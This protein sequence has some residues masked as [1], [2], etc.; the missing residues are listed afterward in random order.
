MVEENSAN[1]IQ[2]AVEGKET[3]STLIRPD[4]DLVVISPRYEQWL[5]LVEVY[6]SDGPIVLLEPVYQGSHA[7]V[8][9]LYCRGMQGDEDPWPEIR[10]LG[11]G[12]GG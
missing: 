2:V 11:K 9:Q 1:V 8:P 6:A 5:C 10:Q 3:S 4:L 12:L 7:V